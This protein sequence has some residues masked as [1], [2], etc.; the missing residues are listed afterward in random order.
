MSVPARTRRPASGVDLVYSLTQNS[1]YYNNKRDSEDLDLPRTVLI[2]VIV[3]LVL[4]RTCSGG[5]GM[6]AT[7]AKRMSCRAV[8]LPFKCVYTI[9]FLLL[10]A[11]EDGDSTRYVSDAKVE[12]NTGAAGAHAKVKRRR[13]M[14]MAVLS[15]WV[16]VWGTHSR[17]APK[18]L[19]DP[20]RSSCQSL[21]TSELSRGQLLLMQPSRRRA[22]ASRGDLVG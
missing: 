3:L 10:Q 6:A 13:K 12:G 19:F 8:R 7:G 5:G 4:I 16:R 14:A 2:I 22:L 15:S 21:N 1:S 20:T 9:W 11:K 17:G 18:V